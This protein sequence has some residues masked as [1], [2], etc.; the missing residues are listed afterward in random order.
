MQALLLWLV[1]FTCSLRCAAVYA[2]RSA[3]GAP[4]HRREGSKKS[5][6]DDEI[7]KKL[8][9]TSV[10]PHLISASNPAQSDP[11]VSLGILLRLSPAEVVCGYCPGEKDLGLALRKP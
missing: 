8:R 7:A 6:L 3:T 10:L 1:V 9:C 11:F 2:T 5:E 4:P